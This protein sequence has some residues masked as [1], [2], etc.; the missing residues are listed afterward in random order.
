MWLYLDGVQST[1]IKSVNMTST[2]Y[3]DL[4]NTIIEL[5]LIDARLCI[6]SL[7]IDSLGNFDYL[8]DQP[9]R[10]LTIVDNYPN[11]YRASRLFWSMINPRRKTIYHL[12]IE[13]EQTYHHQ[14]TNHSTSI[15][16]RT[17][18]QIHQ[19]TF[20]D[21]CRDYFQKLQTQ[22]DEHCSSVEEFCQKTMIS[23]KTKGTDGLNNMSTAHNTKKKG[24]QSTNDLT[25]LVH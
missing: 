9:D 16:P 15:H 8:L 24:Y 7:Q 10:L 23:K 12:H 1:K 22:I 17:N 20:Y 25:F 6:G 18:E 3:G 21:T 11:H 13:I 5:P 19:E 14:A 4:S 2:V